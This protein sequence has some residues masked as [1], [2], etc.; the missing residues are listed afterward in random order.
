MPTARSIFAAA[1]LTGLTVGCPRKEGAGRPTSPDDATRTSSSHGAAGDEGDSAAGAARAA[2]E[3]ALLTLA[4]T[5]QPERPVTEADDPRKSTGQALALLFERLPVERLTEAAGQLLALAAK[6]REAWA[7]HARPERPAAYPAQEEFLIGALAVASA[8]LGSGE[9]PAALQEQA[10]STVADALRESPTM[11]GANVHRAA[12]DA[13]FEAAETMDADD[14]GRLAPALVEALFID[15]LPDPVG[16]ASQVP[17]QPEPL[18]P[19]VRRALVRLALRGDDEREAVVRALLEALT[20]ELLPD[21]HALPGVDSIEPNEAVALRALPCGAALGRAC[22]EPEAMLRELRDRGQAASRAACNRGKDPERADSGFDWGFEPGRVWETV[23][24]VLPYVLPPARNG[25][26]PEGSSPTALAIRLLTDQVERAGTWADEVTAAKALHD[27]IAGRYPDLLDRRRA[28]IA[29]EPRDRPA[30]SPGV[31]EQ[32][33]ALRAARQ[34]QPIDRAAVLAAAAP[35]VERLAGPEATADDVA[36]AAEPLAG[37]FSDLQARLLELADFDHQSEAVNFLLWRSMAA[38]RALGALGYVGPED[39]TLAALLRFARLASQELLGFLITPLKAFPPLLLRWK[40]RFDAAGAARPAQPVLPALLDAVGSFQRPTPAV[41]EFLLEQIGASMLTGENGNA[42]IAVERYLLLNADVATFRALAARAFLQTFR[43]AAELPDADRYLERFRFLVRDVL[44]LTALEKTGEREPAFQLW[45]PELL[46][47]YALPPPGAEPGE[48][49]PPAADVTVAEPVRPPGYSFETYRDALARCALGEPESREDLARWRRELTD[50]QQTQYCTTFV[51]PWAS[52]N[53]RSG[54]DTEL[55]RLQ[56][57]DRRCW[58]HMKQRHEKQFQYCSD[59]AHR[60]TPAEDLGL[61]R[62]ECRKVEE[63]DDTYLYCVDLRFMPEYVE[64]GKPTLW[65]CYDR[66]PWLRDREPV[67]PD[68]SHLAQRILA[69]WLYVKLRSEA[70]ITAPDGVTFESLSQE[71]R[72]SLE[73]YLG[74][75]EAW[76]APDE[77]TRPLLPVALTGVI[78]QLARVQL[79]F[80]EFVRPPD[81]ASQTARATVPKPDDAASNSPPFVE[82]PWYRHEGWTTRVARDFGSL[83]T[84]LEALCDDPAGEGSTDCFPA[85]RLFKRLV[86]RPANGS[87]GPLFEDAGALAVS[88]V[89]GDLAGVGDLAAALDKL[90]PCAGPAGVDAACA[91]AALSPTAEPDPRRR[92]GGQ[93]AAL[94]L[95]TAG[96]TTT[97]TAAS[98]AALEE[99]ICRMVMLAAEPEGAIDPHLRPVIEFAFVRTRPA[100]GGAADAGDHWSGIWKWI[101]DPAAARPT[102]AATPPAEGPPAGHGPGTPAEAG[103]PRNPGSTADL[104]LGEATSFG[105]LPKEVIRRIVQQHR[106]RIRHCYEAA[107]RTQPELAGR[108]TVKFTI[109]AAGAVDSAEAQANT[110]G[111][112]SLG[113]CIVAV[114]RRM[115]FPQADGVTAVT[116]PFALQVIGPQPAP[117]AEPPSGAGGPTLPRQKPPSPALTSAARSVFHLRREGGTPRACAPISTTISPGRTKRSWSTATR[118]SPR[119]CRRS[120]AS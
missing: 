14:A 85:D 68:C 32:L 38:A 91:D 88:L 83:A 2:A 6:T 59:V 72:P 120:R 11:Q 54:H 116:Y 98:R 9:A 106:G 113:A 84:D 42:T 64:R 60:R 8:V 111:D 78:G 109:S 37:A 27:G 102:V 90:V 39:R 48:T 105:D 114:V 34:A 53:T 108:V 100:C 82:R 5:I 35:L 12:A 95:L 70:G 117:A 57:H 79:D 1:L 44:P 4:P 28:G 13:V 61:S 65:G 45:P 93:A 56:I 110:T 80:P 103:P 25:L 66:F 41:L 24:D 51:E 49:P 97:T 29:R 20:V 119:C 71:S 76:A 52:E 7:C 22:A 63:D 55:Q 107:L 23:C 15:P 17:P 77:S 74:F 43:R 33:E 36:A 75:L 115:S 58:L 112:E 89:R 31:Q 26:P 50:E 30:P 16:D 92:L 69:A 99:P 40:G 73:D 19:Y 47:S 21:Q 46:A 87:P 96:V 67:G 104:Q 118:C 18:R 86:A 10:R 94:Y 81:P 3:Q 101:L 62:T